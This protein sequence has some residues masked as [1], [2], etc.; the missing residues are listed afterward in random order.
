ML[1]AAR[2]PC[3]APGTILRMRTWMRWGLAVVLAALVLLAAA[4]LV[5]Q[6]WAG[7][8][9]FRARVEREA[10]V[11]LGAKLQLRSLSVDLWPLPAVAADN[12]RLL[13]QPPVT[14]ER[15][16]V[17]PAWWPML[18][19]KFLAR[20]LVVRKAVLPQ[21]PAT[22]DAHVRL[23]DDGALDELTFRV[24]E[25]R[26]AGARGDVSRAADHWPVHVAIGGGDIR[27]KLQLVP[28]KGDSRVL[29]GD[30]QTQDVEVAALTAPSRALTGKLQATTRL[31]AEFKELGALG[32][33]MRT[34]TQFTVRGAV[35]HGLDLASAVR[36]V[37]MSRGGQTRLD[38]LTGQ[39]VTQ[40]KAV[41]LNNLAASSGVL[42]ASGNVSVSPAKALG[43]QVTVQLAGAPDKLA[44]PLSLG[45]T[46]DSPSVTLS[47]GS[48]IA[49]KL[50]NAVRGL[51]GK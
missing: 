4:A 50:G 30:L 18:Q 33:A 26:F 43:G 51:F 32:D 25:G 39:L 1:A 12:I 19:G 24:V 47:R 34:Q 38:A 6:R 45:G 44:V 10:S 14:V 36:T 21:L 41:Q 28:G 23:G 35:L 40:G 7:S 37:G 20:A 22:V 3:W 2:I 9:D 11:A 49:E 17:R 13:S 16:E 31:R 48:A 8:D 29:S 27:G 5:L 42:A 46:V 15:L